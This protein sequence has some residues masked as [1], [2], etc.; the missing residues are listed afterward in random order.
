MWIEHNF[1]EQHP[2]SHRMQSSLHPSP[3]VS[4]A[5]VSHWKYH[6]H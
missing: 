6:G 3:R 5:V 2:Q 4:V 1:R